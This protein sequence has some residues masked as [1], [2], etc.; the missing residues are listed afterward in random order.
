MA[1]PHRRALALDVALAVA[2]TA[3]ILAITPNIA[4]TGEERELDPLAYAT[5][6]VAGAS[7][8]LRRRF[9]RAVLAVITVALVIYTRRAYPG[10]PVYLT[11]VAPLYTLA[12][13][14][15]ARREALVPAAVAVAVTI[16]GGTVALPQD[17]EWTWHAAVFPGW[18]AAALFLGEAAGSRRAY[19]A[20]LEERARYLEETREEEARRRVAEERLRIARDLHDMIAHSI[21]TINLQ[22]GVAAHVLER[23]PDQAGEALEAIRRTSGAALQELRATLDLLRSPGEPGDAGAPRT[24]TPALARVEDLAATAAEAG[25]PVHVERDGTPTELPATV[26]VAGYR[27]VQES[28]TNVMRHAGATQARVVIR[29]TDDA[30]DIEVTDDGRGAAAGPAGNGEG[31]GIAG[32]RERAALVGGTLEAG[33]KPGGGYRVRAHLP[34]GS[35]AAGDGAQ[36]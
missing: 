21:A 30:V 34:V 32:M 1:V 35:A 18:A 27:I 28:I 22:S 25:L 5:M 29:R 8:A 9:P 31:H 20:G 12:A 6:A 36:T 15:K 33:P 10:G 3:A 17:I 4:P 19:L 2:A 23:R 7:L 13:Q 11:M 14:A 26:D 24:P 16:V